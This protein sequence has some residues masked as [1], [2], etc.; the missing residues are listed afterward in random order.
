M[1]DS[2]RVLIIDDE[3]VIREGCERALAGH[4]YEITKAPNGTAGLSILEEED[5]HV[6]LLDLMMPGIDGFTVLK[7][8]RENRPSINVIVITGFA[9]VEKAVMAMKEGA[10][11]F[12]GK[13]FTPDYIRIVVQR[14]VEKIALETET[15]KLR[16]EKS[17]DLAAIAEEQSRLRTV[18][19][20]MDEAVLVTDHKGIVVLHNPAVIEVLEIQADPVIGKHLSESMRDTDALAMVEEVI[21]DG[22]AITREFEAG[23]ISRLYLRAHC[24]PVRAADG[25]ILGSVT[26]YEDIST[27]KHIDQLKSDFVA[28]VAHELRAPLASIEQMIYALPYSSTDG[29]GEAEKQK[30]E[31]RRKQIFSRINTRIKELLQLIENLLNL[32]KL[33]SGTV[34]FNLEPALGD[35]IINDSIQFLTPQAEAKEIAL[36][37]DRSS[38]EWWINADNDQIRGVFMNIIGNA[39]KYTP[40]GGA[41][42]IGSSVSAGLAKINVTDTGVG[43]KSEDLPNIFDRFFRSKTKA[44]RGIT[45]SGLGLSVVKKVIEAHNGFIAV[46]SELEKGTTFTLSFPVADHP[47]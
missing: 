8:I 29:I 39:I 16:E 22:C 34:V 21:R 17:L 15:A 25:D 31:E 11:D 42:T 24:A 36:K 18:F 43:I 19:T 28:M 32:S 14:A 1:G 40:N 38:K 6:V 3:K 35:D 2:I 27:H 45:G 13:P 7:W 33:E 41:V 9:T 12:V 20:C 4:G 47:A 26:V 44:T 5:F 46:E 10:F 37:F 30:K 23:T